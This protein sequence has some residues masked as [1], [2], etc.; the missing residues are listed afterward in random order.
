MFVA[1]INSHRMHPC[2][3]QH[4]M[5]PSPHTVIIPHPTCLSVCL[6]T[7]MTLL[8]FLCREESLSR[9]CQQ[10]GK[11]W[12]SLHFTFSYPHISS[13]S[14]HIHIVTFTTPLHP[15][16]S[17]GRFYSHNSLVANCYLG[18]LCSIF[19]HITIFHLATLSFSHC[20]SFLVAPCDIHVTCARNNSSASRVWA[21]VMS[22]Y[23]VG[24]FYS[25]LACCIWVDLSTRIS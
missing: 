2:A 25:W 1:I 9:T 7:T 6:I 24:T 17:W 15:V 16:S 10:L 18:H 20:Q 23:L 21:D 19:H 12:S 3:C 14:P 8:A 5:L 22:S 4:S 11:S 13:H